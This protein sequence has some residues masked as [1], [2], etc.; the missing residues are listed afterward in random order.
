MSR[1]YQVHEFA[2]LAGVTVKT[3][4][5]YDRLG[6]LKAGRTDAGYRLYTEADLERL[7]QVRALKLLGLSLKQIKAVLHRAALELPDALRLQRRVLEEKRQLLARAINAINEAERALVPGKTADAAIL[8]RIFEVMGVQE[9]IDVMK[10]YYSEEAWVKG[11]RHY[12][13]WPSQEWN[14]LYHDVEAVFGE[15]PAGEMAQSLA[16]RWMR[17]MESETGGDAELRWGMMAA[18]NDRQYWPPAL[19]QRISGFDLDN[20]WEFIG[21]AIASYRKY[22][23]DEVWAGMAGLARGARQQ[24]SAAWYELFLEVWAA[25]GEDAA[26]E[27]AQALAARWWE[28]DP[29]RQRTQALVARWK[30]LAGRPAEGSDTMRRQIA[31]FNIEKVW[32]FIAKA[33]Y[34]AAVK[35]QRW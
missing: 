31:L 20:I 10:R 28:L 5:H 6:L 13:Q 3:L 4:H 1:F 7:E 11:R 17:L 30:E 16:A 8:R 27:T 32:G 24:T 18:W 23:S 21:K 12:E 29:A 34:V 26:S 15:D 33:T 9:S 2:E 19:Q 14:E 22:Y 35:R 25:L